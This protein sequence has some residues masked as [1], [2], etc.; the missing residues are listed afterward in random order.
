MLPGALCQRPDSPY[1][2]ALLENDVAKFGDVFNYHVYTAL[3]EYP[4]LISTLRSVLGRY[5]ID[6]RAIWVTESGTHL[7]GQSREDGAE[8]GMKAH[9]P[10]QELVLAEY[11][12]KSQIA[13][14]MAGVSRNYFF[15]FGTYNEQGG[16][17]DWGVMRRDGTVK[18][19]YAAI[20][21][22]T[23]ELVSARLV[24][25]IGVGNGL[26]AYLFEQSDGSQT[27]VFWSVSQLDTAPGG[28]VSAKP[29]CVRTLRLA[30]P[31][32]NYRLT[33]TCG[34]RSVA[35]AKG[36]ALALES[37]RYPSY[38]SGFRGLK[39][40]VSALPCGKALPYVAS[41]DEDL[42]V[43]LRAEFDEKDFEISNQK[44][45]AVLK[46]DSGRVRV[47]VWNLGETSKTG[48]VEVAGARL[49]GLPAKP[50]ALGPRGSAPVV[51][52]CT[53][54]PDVGDPA[55]TTLVLTGRFG[56]RRSSRLCASL[57][58]ER[59]F[60]ASLERVPVA[61]RDTRE[62]KRN[63]SAQEYSIAWDEAEKAVRFDVVWTNPLTDRWFYPVHALNLPQESLKDACMVE[64]EVKTAQDKVENDFG[65]ANLMLLYE[66]KPIPDRYFA[67]PSPIGSW[68]R[69]FVE[70]GKDDNIED[71]TAFRLGA[72]PKGMK[73]TFWI[74]NLAILR[75]KPK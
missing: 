20:S 68:E 2:I 12:V 60:L 69:R 66:G 55:D 67:Y 7:E 45:R 43:V 46:G 54:A 44:T 4:T 61:W 15:L 14:Q 53:L 70:F 58:V 6:G 1:S 32:G 50:F 49:L 74:R 42:S 41:A 73:C 75:K 48:T 19:V 47:V 16:A 36:G 33:D 8:K 56:G 24:G 52:D 34:T 35:V 11:Y 31:D 63:T 40:D 25:E 64:F 23:R 72:N 38:V 28:I 3:S 71:V 62:W 26:R 30:A 5:G 65:C 57:I 22:M 17:K 37:T 29:D 27:V 51:F 21:A 13:L 39:A 10:E 9:T 59:R 18:P